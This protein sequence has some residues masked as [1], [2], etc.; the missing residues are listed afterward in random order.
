[1]LKDLFISSENPTVN[2]PSVELSK[3]TGNWPIEIQ[4]AL[5]SAVPMLMDAEGKLALDELDEDK[6]HGKGSYVV[7]SPD[8]KIIVP[9][10]IKAGNLLPLDVYMHNGKW[11]PMDQ[12]DLGA[13]LMSASI[14]TDAVD[15]ADLPPAAGM[16]MSLGTPPSG[17]GP[18]AGVV[19]SITNKMAKAM[20]KVTESIEKAL[21]ENRDLLQKLARNKAAKEALQ[22][23]FGERKEQIKNPYLRSDS[24]TTLMGQGKFLVK[25]AEKHSLETTSVVLN[26]EQLAGFAK[27]AG[28]SAE[29]I[30]HGVLKNHVHTSWDD[31]NVYAVK[32]ASVMPTDFSSSGVYYSYAKEGSRINKAIA[33]VLGSV[34]KA[35]KTKLLVI[36]N[37]G[38]ALTDKIAGVKGDGYVPA[39]QK[40][41]GS[42]RRGD[43]VTLPKSKGEWEEPI[44]IES[45]RLHGQSR[46]FLGSRG[47]EKVA[48]ILDDSLKTTVRTT[49]DHIPTSFMAPKHAPVICMPSSANVIKLADKQVSLIRD[50]VDL[51][52]H[53]YWTGDNEKRA[54]ALPSRMW[55]TGPNS[56]AV[57]IGA[58]NP[59]LVTD[60]EALLYLRK[61]LGGGTIEALQ[62]MAS[63]VVHKFDLSGVIGEE[64]TVKAR[65]ADGETLDKIPDLK[66]VDTMTSLKVAFSVDD[67][68]TVDSVLSLNYVTPETLSEFTAAV[69]ELEKAEDV[70]ARLLVS[71]RLGNETVAEDDV[72]R[73]LT[74]L[75]S[76]ISALR[77]M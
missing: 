62:K 53:M 72:K 12:E 63:G 24:V 57:K 54:S 38:Y 65:I 44:R 43:L 16:S 33:Q 41:A 17:Y 73:T 2:L 39:L 15:P 66:K 23:N 61:G 4:S 64:P 21:M 6:L 11:F 5:F 50:E 58:S 51:R 60:T 22:R 36:T 47:T 52:S 29:A 14:G 18:D 74:S 31:D 59:K 49:A 48:F 30:L 77:S 32:M 76:I 7:D 71:S 42:L 34:K 45:E 46:M 75:H 9:I 37:D 70:L 26:A 25:S 10:I 69:P 28:L 27:A 20:P 56:V 67:E 55:R 40:T 8:G 68:E 3:D 1:M 13:L 35:G 19:S